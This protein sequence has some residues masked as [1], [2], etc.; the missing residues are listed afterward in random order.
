MEN[1]VAIERGKIDVRSHQSALLE[2]EAASLAALEKCS[3]A[4]SAFV[5]FVRE[6]DLSVVH[7]RVR[8]LLK[9]IPA[10]IT[11]AADVPIELSDCHTIAQGI[12]KNRDDIIMMGGIPKSESPF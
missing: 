7:P 1:V 4:S 11:K 12:L 10:L 6:L 5:S 3:E 2:A 8:R 9:R